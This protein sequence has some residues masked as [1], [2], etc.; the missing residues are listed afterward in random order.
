MAPV[1]VE[2]TPDDDAAEEA[3]R[4]HARGY[5]F[6]IGAMGSGAPTS[7]TTRCGRLGLPRRGGRGRASW[8]AG[9]REQAAEAVP[10]EIGRRTNL[11]GTEATI[12]ARLEV[13]RRA[14]ITTLLAKLDG[15]APERLAT[16]ATL[17][18]LADADRSGR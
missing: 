6:T 13:Y 10:V 15:P 2:I 4:R 9:Q 14:G 5:A 7:T 12:A 17:V 16:L 1:A 18:E 8:R 3:A 11:V